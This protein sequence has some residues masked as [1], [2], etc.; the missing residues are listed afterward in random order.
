M[1]H[2]LIP[3]RLSHLLG[4]SGVGAIVRGASGL[5]IVRD[6]RQWTDR[7]GVPA[8]KPIRYVERVRAALG[9][10][11]ELR[12]PPVAKELAN[13][14][15]DG[16]Y[17]PATRF[18]SWMRCPACSA[19]FRSPWR[20]SEQSDHA[21]RCS[22]VDCERHP[23][24]EQMTWVLAHPDGYL[25]DVP[26]HF[27]VH[28]DAR[29]PEQRNCK[30]RDRLK[31]L[32]RG[33]ETRILKCEAC[34]AESR[35]RGDEKVGFGKG[36]MQ[37]WTK[38][39]LVQ[40][41]EDLQ[42]SGEDLAQVLAINDT[43]VYAPDGESVL[44]IPPESRVRKGTVVD[45]LYR[46]S[47]DRRRIGEAKTPL[48]RKSVIRTLAAEYR[49]T[50]D[51]IKAALTDIKRGYPLYGENPTPGQL[52][53]SEFKAFLEVLPDQREDEDLVTR[54]RSEEWRELVN[55]VGPADDQQR[56]I[57]GIRHLVRV[58]RLKAVKVFRGFTR[59]DGK[60]VLPDILGKSDWLPAIELYGEGIFLALDEDRL[61]IWEQLPEVVSRLQPLL[62]RFAQS[63][64][65][66]PNPLTPRF[67]LLHTL[68]HLL[69]RQIE[70]E[71]GYPAASLIERIYCAIAP[72]PMAGI[73]IH[74]AVPDVSGSLGGL[75]EL[76]EP[77]RFL[78]IL[79]R[80]LEHSRWC[81]LDPVC[82]EHE[83]QGPGLLNRAACHACSLVP[84]PACEY[85]N[86]LLD[87]GFVKGDPANG[88]PSFFEMA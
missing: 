41:R 56:T 43:R 84:E 35:F 38:G 39:D 22:H 79:I 10:K 81:S 72:E 34:H 77:R 76:S 74:V 26:W 88:L 29:N 9:I 46:S 73:L 65:D 30:V 51:D 68:S 47:D 25:A 18:P 5:V 52:R 27:L 23:K 75:A 71:G 40:S 24:L 78:G 67:M 59:L 82:G 6:T 50:S 69:M 63:G 54:N 83:G 58:D 15:V 14:Q 36:R 48:A 33:Y 60:T 42:E 3:I 17:M 64:R 7:Q 16:V 31:L 86:T 62:S 53:E 1:R 8:G 19:I 57:Q 87:R 28:K 21:P 66:S 12:E 11:E 80:A 13:G 70:S 55:A 49:S 45:R 44:V 32:E 61:K 2:E 4:H 85:G 20:N 37:P